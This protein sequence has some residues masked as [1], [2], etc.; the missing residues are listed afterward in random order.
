MRERKWNFIP[1]KID[2][3]LTIHFLFLAN[4]NANANVIIN[5]PR[6]CCFSIVRLWFP[7][8][9]IFNQLYKIPC[10]SDDLNYQIR[11]SN[12]IEWIGSAAIIAIIV[13][14][15][16]MNQ[17]IVIWAPCASTYTHTE[18]WKM[19]IKSNVCHCQLCAILGVFSLC[20]LCTSCVYVSNP[21][22][23]NVFDI[24]HTLNLMRMN[25]KRKF[26][27]SGTLVKWNEN[28]CSD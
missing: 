9:L 13:Y 27:R 21:I 12:Q 10:N 1:K 24:R 17:W 22:Q 19:Q 28:C 25:D 4:M 14:D 20:Y 15:Y 5:A 7:L 11:T 8:Y 6:F 16:V 2:F 3:L 23:S 26:N 18:A